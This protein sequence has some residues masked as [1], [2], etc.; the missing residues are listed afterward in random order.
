MSQKHWIEYKRTCIILFIDW[1][2][3]TDLSKPDLLKKFEYVT[4]ELCNEKPNENN[5]T[6]EQGGDINWVFN[7]HPSTNWYF[8]TICKYIK[9]K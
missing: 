7:N 9:I 8:I 5:S 2:K 4:Y 1:F 3:I 6:H